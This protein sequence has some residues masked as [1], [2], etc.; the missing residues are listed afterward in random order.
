MGCSYK[1]TNDYVE[2]TDFRL[3]TVITIRLYDGDEKQLEHCM[4]MIKKYDDM[5]SNE[6]LNSDV[7]IVNESISNPMA[8]HSDTLEIMEKALEYGKLSGGSFD[9]TI[10]A[11]SNLWDFHSDEAILPE[12]AAISEAIKTVDYRQVVINDNTIALVENGSGSTFHTRLDLGGIA[13][14]YIADKLRDYLM[15]EGV[16]SASISLGGNVYIIGEK[17]DGNMFTV[18][19]QKPFSDTSTP[20][21]TLQVRDKSVVTSGV[22]QRYFK[23]GDKIYHHILDPK[24]GYPVDNGLYSVTIISDDS[25]DGDA[26][27]TMVFSMGLKKG[28][29]YVESTPGI[30]AVFITS[31]M[32]LHPSSGMSEYNYQEVR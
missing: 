4:E 14:G 12:E 26:L 31:D 25:V 23:I 2:K 11:V 10:G 19:I 9:V 7:T 29:D 27:S 8:V 24:T 18:G 28:M 21:C 3:D 6:Q 32:A 1:N 30:E 22:Y 16:T 20:A 15:E 13:K 5:F 17:P